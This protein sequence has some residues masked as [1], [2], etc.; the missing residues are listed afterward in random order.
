MAKPTFEKTLAEVLGYP[1]KNVEKT[2]VKGTTYQ[3]E[4]IDEMILM[5]AGEPERQERQGVVSFKY[6]VYDPKTEL[7]FAIRVKGE[8]PNDF[9]F[10]NRLK[11]IEVTGGSLNNGGSWFGAE[12]VKKLVPKPQA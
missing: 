2:S 7:N 4:V 10:G 11:F 6:P 3:A 1:S 5:A 9:N 12:E 8:K